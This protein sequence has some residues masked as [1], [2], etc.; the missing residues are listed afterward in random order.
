MGGLGRGSLDGCLGVML[1][2]RGD[3]S[4]DGIDGA[5]QSIP[6]LQ[7]H[8]DESGELLVVGWGGTLGAIRHAVDNARARGLSVSCAHIRYMNPLPANTGEVLK[9]FNKVLV[10]ELNLGQLSF[11]L[12]AKY[13]VDA[14]GLNKVEGQPFKTG[15]I[16]NRI[17][18]MLEQ[19]KLR[20]AGDSID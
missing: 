7:V 15:E 6:D 1:R 18:E 13:L 19:P 8:G 10:P 5:V 16:E 3:A 4:G 2:E 14:V 9:R 20:A 11:I 12:R 17:Y